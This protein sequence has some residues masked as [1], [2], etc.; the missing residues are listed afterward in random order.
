MEEEEELRHI[1]SLI[2]SHEAGTLLESVL[3]L[4]GKIS[5][6]VEC[7]NWIKTLKNSKSFP[8]P[9]SI[10]IFNLIN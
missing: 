9:L 7:T 4:G 10:L 6:A 2:S 3:A 1:K 8:K 5:Q